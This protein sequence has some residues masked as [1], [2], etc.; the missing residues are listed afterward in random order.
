[1]PIILLA[2][3]LWILAGPAAARECATA[4]NT[5]IVTP[6]KRCPKGSKV[7][8]APH[9]TE[10]KAAPPREKRWLDQER[11][12]TVLRQRTEA[13]DF[14]L[15]LGRPFADDA[16]NRRRLQAQMLGNECD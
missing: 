13:I 16:R 1:M 5:T 7:L 14:R 11:D 15:R 6:G 10:R 12:C 9:R 3:L 4:T 2:A 8:R